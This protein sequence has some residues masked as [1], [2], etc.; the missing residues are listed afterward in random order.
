MLKEQNCTIEKQEQREQEYVSSSR[1]IW[2][3][4]RGNIL[5]NC[6]GWKKMYPMKSIW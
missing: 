3:N 5:V 6:L 4:M 2:F 1:C